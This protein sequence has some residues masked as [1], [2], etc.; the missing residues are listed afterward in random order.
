MVISWD[1]VVPALFPD[2]LA[3]FGKTAL[4]V[5]IKILLVASDVE[6]DAPYQD[7]GG[8]FDCGGTFA[9]NLALF[10]MSIRD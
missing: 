10:R 5:I 4:E 8:Q 1:F 3:I 9:V 7:A 6:D 2:L